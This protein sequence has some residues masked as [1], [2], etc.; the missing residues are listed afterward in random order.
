[1][2]VSVGVGGR[3]AADQSGD[4]SWPRPCDTTGVKTETGG[5]EASLLPSPDLG[6]VLII[7]ASKLAAMLFV[8]GKE[9]SLA[10]KART[11]FMLTTYN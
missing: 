11:S 5:G 7:L 9:L 4:F 1:M 3:A 2:G 10:R 6:G 8:A